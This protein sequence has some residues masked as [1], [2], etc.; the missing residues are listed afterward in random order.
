MLILLVTRIPQLGIQQLLTSVTPMI[1]LKLGTLADFSLSRALVLGLS[2]I[3]GTHT[4]WQF[5]TLYVPALIPF[6]LISFFNSLE[7]DLRLSI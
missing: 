2:S 7:R 5:Q 6:F 3:F 4:H 1:E